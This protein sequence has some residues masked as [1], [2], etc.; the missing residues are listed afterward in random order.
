MSIIPIK[1]NKI[2]LKIFLEDDKRNH[3]Y[4]P[5]GLYEEKS[6]KL[7]YNNIIIFSIIIYD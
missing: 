2:L 1:N 4:I 6:N 3:C 5:I 7:I